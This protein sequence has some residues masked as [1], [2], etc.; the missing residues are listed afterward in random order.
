LLLLFLSDHKD[1]YGAAQLIEDS[2]IAVVT[3]EFFMMQVV[4]IWLVVQDGHPRPFVP[5]VMYLSAHYRI[6]NPTICEKEME[7]IDVHNSEKRPQIRDNHLSWT[8]INGGKRERGRVLM[9][10]L[11]KPSIQLWMMQHAVRPIEHHLVPKQA[12]DKTGQLFTLAR[13]G[14][15]ILLTVLAAFKADSF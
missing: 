12:Y 13:Q 10:L 2:D 5:A 7:T 4:D 9:V 6:D 11:V 1:P 14:P 15:L 3:T 8:T